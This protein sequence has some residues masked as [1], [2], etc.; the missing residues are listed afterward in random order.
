MECFKYPKDTNKI[1]AETY[2]ESERQIQFDTNCLESSKISIM[3]LN[4][5]GEIGSIKQQKIIACSG[6]HLA[7]LGQRKFAPPIGTKNTLKQTGPVSL[8]EGDT[9]RITASNQ[10]NL[11]RDL[12]EP[13]IG[14]SSMKNLSIQFTARHRISGPETTLINK[15]EPFPSKFKYDFKKP[16]RSHRW[17]CSPDR[18]C[19]R[20]EI[21]CRRVNIK[22]EH[23]RSRYSLNYKPS[24][25]PLSL[26]HSSHS[27]PNYS[28]TRL[29]KKHKFK[30]SQLRQEEE[31]QTHLDTTVKQLLTEGVTVTETT[32]GYVFRFDE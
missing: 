24:H 23:V 27:V 13:W 16:E 29:I 1:L 3:F 17:S 14:A 31:C 8:H 5:I 4:Q 22:Q 9:E 2:F 18:E 7:D 25:K 21:T 11:L 32:S 20:N 19:N 28:I 6:I 10:N 30:T 15:D 26:E 12:E